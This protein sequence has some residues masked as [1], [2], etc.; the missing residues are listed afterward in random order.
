MSESRIVALAPSSR[1]GRP[2]YRILENASGILFCPCDGFKW[3]GDCGHLKKYRAGELPP[4]RE[5][6]VIV[7]TRITFSGPSI[8][9]GRIVIEGVEVPLEAFKIGD[10]T[11]GLLET[12]ERLSRLTGLSVRIATD[13]E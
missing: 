10:L 2:P 1:K 11:G 8:P 7:K 3:R 12:E 9:Q 4:Y 13:A 6:E 5:D